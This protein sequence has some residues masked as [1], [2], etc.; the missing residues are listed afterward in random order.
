MSRRRLTWRQWVGYAG[1]GLVF[2][3][4]AAVLI[5]RGDIL[6]AGLDPQV[7][8]QTYEPP[9]APDYGSAD[10]WALSDARAAGAGPAAIFFVHS[11]TY[12]GDDGWNGTVGDPKAD[13]Y[14]HRVVIPNYAGP[15]ARAGAVSAPLYRQSSLYTRLTLRDDAREARAFAYQDIDRAFAH[16]LAQHPDRPII[17]AGVEQGAELVARLISQRF[18]QDETLRQRLVAAY[19]MDALVPE[20][21]EPM[22]PACT[23]RSDVGCLVGWSQIG[24]GD[25]GAA[26]RRLRRAL[27]WND[28]GRLIE[29]GERPALCV[30]P[31]SGQ[32]NEEAVPA[33]RH[34]GAANAT[35]MEWGLRPAFIDRQIATQCRDGLLW[36][37]VLKSE[38]FRE[39]SGWTARRKARPYNLFYADLEADALAR[40][41][42]WQAGQTS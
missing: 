6:K 33:R 23:A 36:H 1:F 2:V 18:A 30:N 29:L 37:T 20:D 16:W 41:E 34:L 4:V 39:L 8:F 12:D 28:R 31:V 21:M 25:E 27:I 9:P 7:P 35:G 11:T 38:S 5:W 19:L 10:T 14:L 40:L 24:E 15:F 13:A 26:R 32:N 22:V 42:A 17:L 3:L